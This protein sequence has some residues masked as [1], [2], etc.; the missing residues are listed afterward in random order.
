MLFAGE[1]P[2]NGSQ[3][4]WGIHP[5]LESDLKISSHALCRELEMN[6]S[7]SGAVRQHLSNWADKVSAQT[8]RLNM[9]NAQL[10]LSLSGGEG[11]GTENGHTRLG[12]TPI[13]WFY[14]IQKVTKR[15]FNREARPNGRPEQIWFSEAHR[16]PNSQLV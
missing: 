1:P 5:I 9:D 6:C 7:E 11:Y 14:R 13:G 12:G 16:T 15:V 3:P 10:E 4:Q 2:L 8:E